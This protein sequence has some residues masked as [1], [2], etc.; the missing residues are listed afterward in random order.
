M[1]KNW[2]Q[3]GIQTFSSDKNCV[4]RDGY[5]R[6]APIVALLVFS[7]FV[8]EMGAL[9]RNSQVSVSANEVVAKYEEEAMVRV[10]KNTIVM[11]DIYE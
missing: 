8:V 2:F 1:L 11:G 3:K 9:L 10:S 5:I 4:N 6:R 7:M